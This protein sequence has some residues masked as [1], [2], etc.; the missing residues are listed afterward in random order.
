MLFSKRWLSK[1]LEAYIKIKISIDK[2]YIKA[3][4]VRNSQRKRNE[5]LCPVSRTDL[6]KGKN[7]FGRDIKRNELLNLSMNIKSSKVKLQKPG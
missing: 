4:G 7:H 1:Q 3:C 5:D 2:I 6:A